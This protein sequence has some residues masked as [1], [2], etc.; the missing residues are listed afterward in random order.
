MTDKPEEVE[1]WA[2]WVD[3]YKY[4]SV[5]FDLRGVIPEGYEPCYIIPKA[6]REREREAMREGATML[7]TILTALHEQVHPGEPARRGMITE[8]THW[9]GWR[10]A[11]NLREMLRALGIQEGGG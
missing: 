10:A 7:E 4:P 11:K 6:K 1:G 8:E 5:L 3:H 2:C 9:K